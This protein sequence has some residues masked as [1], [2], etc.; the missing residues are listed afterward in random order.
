VVGRVVQHAI[1]AGKELSA[2]TLDELRRFS[3]RFGED[4]FARLTLQGSVAARDHVG[5]TAPRQVRQAAQRLREYLRRALAESG[6]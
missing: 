2:L 1:G 5:G 3:D 4:V 6:I